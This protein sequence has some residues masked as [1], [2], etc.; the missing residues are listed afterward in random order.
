MCFG[1]GGG[2][3]STAYTSTVTQ[4]DMDRA[5]AKSIEEQ[6]AAKLASLDETK[7]TRVGEGG[8]DTLGSTNVGVVDPYNTPGS[9]GAITR[10]G[11][12]ESGG[13]K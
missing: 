3:N 6:R 8:T 7:L 13:R 11:S 1:G 5:N 10:Y 12:W 4:A 9:Y 2:G